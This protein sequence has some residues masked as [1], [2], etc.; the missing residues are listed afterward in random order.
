MKYVYLYNECDVGRRIFVHKLSQHYLKCDTNYDNPLLNISYVDEKA[1]NR[2]IRYMQRHCGRYT[3]LFVK[4]NQS[5]KI[6]R[7]KEE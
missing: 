3:L 4:D 1:L 7:A 2:Q 6:E 5:F